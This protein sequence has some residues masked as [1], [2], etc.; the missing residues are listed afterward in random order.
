MVKVRY[1]QYENRV[2]LTGRNLIALSGASRASAKE[3]FPFLAEPLAMSER[4]FNPDDA[5]ALN[6]EIADE[7]HEFANAT[8][9]GDKITRLLLRDGEVIELTFG[10]LK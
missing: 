6:G 7:I 10:S 3:L 9:S 8:W 1:K 5:K 4:D 2:D